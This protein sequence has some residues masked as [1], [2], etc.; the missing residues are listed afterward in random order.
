MNKSINWKKVYWSS[1]LLLLILPVTNSFFVNL[2]KITK[3]LNEYSINNLLLGELE[4]QN[5]NIS[6][7]V[8]FY[9]TERG[10][11]NLIKERLDT[12]E[13]GELIIKFKS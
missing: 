12:V 5:Q 1:I 6:N 8:Q 10:Q 4:T 7:R 3:L 11:K 13:D 2:K 9:K